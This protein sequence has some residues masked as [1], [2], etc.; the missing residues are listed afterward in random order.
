MLKKILLI[1]LWIAFA[2]LVQ[3]QRTISGKIIDV[4]TKQAL[5]SASVFLA[6][7]SVGTNANSAGEFKLEIAGPGRFNL[8]VALIGYETYATEVSVQENITGI[9][10]ELKPQVAELA[11]VVVGNYDKNGWEKWGEFFM[12]M[13]IGNTPNAL[14]CKLLNKE[15]VKFTFSKKENILRAFATEPLRIENN[16][17]GF[18]LTYSLTQFEHNYKTRIFYYQGYPLF[19]EKKPRNNRQYQKWISNRKETYKGS[20]MHFMRSLFRNKI[21]E[22]GFEIKKIIKQK[23]SSASIKINGLPLE[24]EIDVLIDKPLTGDS[25]AFAIDDNT[26]GLQFKD[27]LQIV[28][29]NKVMSPLYVRTKRNIALGDPIT[30]KL[31]MPDATKTLSV[32]ANGSYFFG[33]DILTLDYWAWSEKLSNLLPLEY[34]YPQ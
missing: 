29:K 31:F 6:N 32:L 18:D 28:Y 23:T 17:L 7:T 8:V 20:L 2:Q 5:A 1:V 15:A 21:I 19:S 4:N 9:K 30:A 34:R 14:N 16:A 11:E 24:E 10:I 22:E 13:L 27:Y 26:A 25:I 3:A 33:R 12:E